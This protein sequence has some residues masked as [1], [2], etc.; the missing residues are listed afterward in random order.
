MM[1]QQSPKYAYACPEHRVV[2]PPATGGI[3]HNN[4]PTEVKVCGGHVAMRFNV[5]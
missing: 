4:I 3:C 1:H 2:D 5:S